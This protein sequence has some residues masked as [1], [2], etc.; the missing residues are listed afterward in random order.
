MTPCTISLNV[1]MME[2]T[3][4]HFLTTTR[5]LG[6]SFPDLFYLFYAKLLNLY[7]IS[8]CVAMDSATGGSI[9]QRPVN[10]TMVNVRH[11]ISNTLLVPLR[12][13][14]PGLIQIIFPLLE[15]VFVKAE[16]I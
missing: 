16:F 1:N 3:V 5:S 7:S 14:P 4:V 12:F 13:F 10:L 2:G 11:S 9:I 8:M 6:E 15:M